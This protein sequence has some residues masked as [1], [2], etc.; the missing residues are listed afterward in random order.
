MKRHSAS[1][2][3][4]ILVAAAPAQA[5]QAPEAPGPRNVILMISDGAGFNGWLAADYY[6]G[7]AGSQ[8]YQVSD[9]RF[10]EHYIGASAHYA[11][12]LIDET[13]TIL[14]NDR[15]QAAAGAE[16]QGY[17]PR[18]RWTRL[19]GAFEHDF[20]DVG[21]SYTSYTDSA[22]AGTAIHAG[23]KTVSGRVNTNW[24]ETT[25]FETIAHIADRKGLATGLVTTVQV[26]PC[27][28]GVRL[29]PSRVAQS[30]RGDFQ[31]DGRRPSRRHHGHGSSAL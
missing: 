18:E 20:G 17:V 7:K 30:V 24:D 22:A 29:G 11:L 14:A 23:R 19:D 2:I 15:L 27:H 28:T 13:G 5:A 4:T 10:G 31:S 1:I 8:P 12:R 3:A 26:L 9:D 6:E 25:P 21:I 16:A